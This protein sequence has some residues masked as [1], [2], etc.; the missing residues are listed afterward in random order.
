MTNS[1]AAYYTDIVC[2]LP[3][4]PADVITFRNSGGYFV[5]G[6]AEVFP[7]QTY[8]LTLS[9]T[10]QGT[11]RLPC[12]D[13][14]GVTAVRWNIGLPDDDIASVSIAYSATS[15][16]LSDVLASTATT[17]TPDAVTAALAN[18]ANKVSGAVAGN[19][20]S[21]T[22]GGDLADSGS[23]PAD[24]DAAGSAA[25]VAGNL[26]THEGLTG[27]A[28]HGLGS[29]SVENT[30][31]FEVGGAVAAHDDE[32]GHANGDGAIQFGSDGAGTKR[33]FLFNLSEI[34]DVEAGIASDNH[35]LRGVYFYQLRSHF[36]AGRF[37]HYST[38][39]AI[40]AQYSA[41]FGWSNEA[42]DP[43]PTSTNGD[44]AKGQFMAGY[45][46]IGWSPMSAGLGMYNALLRT[47]YAFGQYNY[48]GGSP[49]NVQV[50]NWTSPTAANSIEISG[51]Q[52]A[53]YV[54]GKMIAVYGCSAVSGETEFFYFN[55][56]VTS[57]YS[58]GTGRTT[59]NLLMPLDYQ[60]ATGAGFVDS[61]NIHHVSFVVPAPASSG[62]PT[63][64]AF[65][66]Y[67]DVRADSLALGT[68]NLILNKYGV[69]FGKQAIVKN[70]GEIA[71]AGGYLLDGS[72]LRFAQASQ[73][74]V[75]K[76]TAVTTATA[77]TLDGAAV[78][79]TTNQIVLNEGA[80]YRLRAAVVGILYTRADACAIDLEALVFRD[81]SGN[82]TIVGQSTLR[83]HIGAT[84]G[85]STAEFAV[86]ATN[87]A[88]QV[89][90]TPGV[91][92][93]TI[94]NAEVAATIIGMDIP[95][96]TT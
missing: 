61:E 6:N 41:R 1:N 14:T 84:M 24:F 15:Q 88:I 59:V 7:G 80:A 78:S 22:S 28:V 17:T 31:A 44:Q 51:D 12:P 52:T 5:S 21:L 82:V 64:V 81:G 54:A 74:L 32:S 26:T 79:T 4:Y 58:A 38:W 69:A 60:I 27:T 77:L 66:R 89:T 95:T 10:G 8:T 62:N 20:A 43:Y 93:V 94:W 92:S 57:S 87:K 96:A 30:S 86:D 34:P 70:Q 48:I 72:S 71:R 18:K 53:D 19:L 25:T 68:D 45:G 63:G 73:W 9:A 65:G 91:N 75:K 35:D 29:A 46:N 49:N 67:N 50:H 90:V 37:N 39:G 13:N 56:V 36:A 33:D 85:A 55:Q 3:D 2:D 42:I 11:Q 23:A 83:S 47:G 16:D 40:L 76:K